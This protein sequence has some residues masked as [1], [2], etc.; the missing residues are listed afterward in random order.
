[1]APRA[2][3]IEVKCL[4]AAGAWP[5]LLRALGDATVRSAVTFYDTQDLA[6]HRAGAILRARRYDDGERDTTV[7]LRG[8]PVAAVDARF[9]GVKG[10]KREVDASVHGAVPAVALKVEAEAGEPA[11][12]AAQ[13]ALLDLG[14]AVV[15]WSALGQYG[16]TQALRARRDG[17]TAERW[18]VGDDAVIEVST[19]GDGPP[20]AQLATLEQWLRAAGVT[21][22][23]GLDG[24]KTTWAL[25][26]H[27][28]RPLHPGP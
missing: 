12:T 24:G 10:F 21:P 17:I 18:S 14:V 8:S 7:K 5:A 25:R 28:W 27:R 19:R 4:V 3:R 1:M 9:D 22:A 2:E 11:F 23:G 26:R 20:D 13:L 15:R 6:L 16:P